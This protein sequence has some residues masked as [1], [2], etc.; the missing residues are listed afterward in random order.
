MLERQR[1]IM[2]W[3]SV[4][5]FICRSVSRF[6]SLIFLSTSVVLNI[7]SR[8][9]LFRDFENYLSLFGGLW[10]W[11]P[12]CFLEVIWPRYDPALHSTTWVSLHVPVGFVVGWLVLHWGYTLVI[13]CKYGGLGQKMYKKS[14]LQIICFYRWCSHLGHVSNALG[15]TKKK[16]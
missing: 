6:I 14:S 9:Q 13:M 8:Y 7:L 5:R 16:Y 15:K 3:S 1:E 10:F 4:W 12:T 2:F 11:A